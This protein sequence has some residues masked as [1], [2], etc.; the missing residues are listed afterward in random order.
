[1]HRERCVKRALGMVLERSRCT[2]RRHHGVADELLDRPAGVLDLGRHG[3]VEAVEQ[4]AC[5][6]GIL[7]V[8]E[9]GRADE[10][11]EE[12]S[13]ELALLGG[14]RPLLEG[15]RTGRAETGVSR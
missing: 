13:R 14:H 10:V 3:V 6:L 4:H 1:M 8:G 15:C 12:D 9:P 11:S 5:A 7:R 2:E